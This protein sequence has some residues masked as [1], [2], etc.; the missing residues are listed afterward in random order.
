MDSAAVVILLLLA[1][2]GVHRE[3]SAKN[4]KINSLIQEKSE[5]HNALTRDRA[6]I[7]I[8]AFLISSVDGNSVSSE[9]GDQHVFRIEERLQAAV[10]EY[11]D[12]EKRIFDE[13]SATSIFD[14]IEVDRSAA[15]IIDIFE[16]N[17]L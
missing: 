12:R 2:Y 3:I 6:R 14:S 4:L 7:R 1:A 8:L 13:D 17:R 15:K 16:R 9:Y 10:S 5:I 11:M